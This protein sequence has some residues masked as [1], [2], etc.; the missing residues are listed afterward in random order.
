MP[1]SLFPPALLK[2]YPKYSL[3]I[4]TMNTSLLPRKITIA[5]KFLIHE[6]KICH[7]DF[8]RIIKK[9]HSGYILS[10]N[11]KHNHTNTISSCDSVLFYL[12]IQQT[13][14]KYNA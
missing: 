9:L 14:S 1:S 2:W 4:G 10:K 7:N 11:G 5:P 6:I 13:L 3:L 12:F 8:Q